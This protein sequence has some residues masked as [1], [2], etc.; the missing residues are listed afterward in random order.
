VMGRWAEPG[1]T[2]SAGQSVLT[3][4]RTDRPYTRIYV[5]E[6]VLPRLKVGQMLEATL[7]GYPD[8]RF[9]GRIAALADK[10]EYTPRV[11]LTET[12]RADLLFGVKVE[13]ADPSGMLKAGLPLNVRLP[14]SP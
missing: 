5:G 14:A 7:D 8:R 12:E 2:V 4:G 1:E 11:A 10:A 6:K 3:V 13:F 9:R